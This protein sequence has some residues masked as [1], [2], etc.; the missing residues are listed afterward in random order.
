[1]GASWLDL[2][3][4]AVMSLLTLRGGQSALHRSKGQVQF[5][6]SAQPFFIV[7]SQCY[8]LNTPSFMQATMLSAAT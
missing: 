3:D 5:A 6:K 4:C 2:W 8:I 7:F 1:M